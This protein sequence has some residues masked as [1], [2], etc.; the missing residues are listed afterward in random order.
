MVSGSTTEQH[1]DSLAKG[2]MYGC[3]HFGFTL[4]C[5]EDDTNY[6][7][8]WRLE[9]TGRELAEDYKEFKDVEGT[10]FS[11]HKNDFLQLLEKIIYR[12]CQQQ[13]N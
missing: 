1:W 11:V 3:N 9:Y 12:I 5:P 4:F 10:L 2:D 7:P 8:V 13:K 6:V